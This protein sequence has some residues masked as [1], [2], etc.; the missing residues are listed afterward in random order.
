MVNFE[1]ETAL[2]EGVCDLARRT[3]TADVMIESLLGGLRGAAGLKVE[4]AMQLVAADIDALVDLVADAAILARNL[5]DDYY[6]G[7]EAA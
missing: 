4:D 1:R 7:E 2:E 6:G 5:R 3:H